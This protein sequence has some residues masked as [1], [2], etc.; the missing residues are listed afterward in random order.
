MTHTSMHKKAVKDGNAKS[1]SL[2]VSHPQEAHALLR[3]YRRGFGSPC[4][5]ECW[6]G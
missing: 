6:T 4:C 2:G 5:G 3:R 1:T